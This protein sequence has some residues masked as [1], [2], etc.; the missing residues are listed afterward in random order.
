VQ[1]SSDDSKALSDFRVAVIGSSVA[2]GQGSSVGK[3]W[4]ELFSHAL[5][6]RYAKQCR[7]VVKNFAEGGST[8]SEALWQFAACQ[9]QFT[10]HVVIVSLSLGTWSAARPS[11][12]RALILPKTC[13]A[14][15]GLLEV[16]DQ[17]VKAFVAGMQRLIALAKASSCKHLVVGGLYPNNFYEGEH[18]AWIKLVTK[19]MQSWKLPMLDFLSTTDD[20]SG[21][22]KPGFAQDPF[23]PNNKGH[24]AMAQAAVSTLPSI[25]DPVV[26]QLFG[27]AAT[28]TAAVASSPSSAATNAAV[29]P[30]PP[31]TAPPNSTPSSSSS[32]SNK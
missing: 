23:H 11:A 3:S 5:A 22:W 25:F 8:T 31:I 16:P 29:S 2:L 10:P 19:E 17:A 27:S 14:N 20:G 32:S 28:A 18:Y 1:K 13:V 9:K 6:Q 30:S 21:C 12:L 15:E 26:Q 7:V 4:V 24:A